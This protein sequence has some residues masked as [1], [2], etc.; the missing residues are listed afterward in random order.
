MLI[1]EL[2]FL[3]GVVKYNFDFRFLGTEIQQQMCAVRYF[4]FGKLVSFDLTATERPGSRVYFWVDWQNP[5]KWG[6]D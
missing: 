1:W 3:A 4:Q 6:G 5:V 2:C